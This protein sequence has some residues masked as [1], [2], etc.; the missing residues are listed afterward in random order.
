MAESTFSLEKEYYALFDIVNKFDDRLI[1]VKGWSVTLSLAA[2]GSG[3][4]FQHYGLFLVACLSGIGFWMIDAV[5]KRHQMRYYA[6]MREIEV[7]AI[8]TPLPTASA[9]T[10]Q[11]DWSWT[12]APRYFAGAKPLTPQWYRVDPGKPGYAWAWILP[13]VMLPHIISVIAGLLFFLL[14]MSGSF[15]N[16][17]W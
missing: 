5:M 16:M 8:D 9:S 2:L 15:G 1:T 10:P 6:R 14:G 11:I 4:Q 12:Q 17:T 13:H 7:V 3:F